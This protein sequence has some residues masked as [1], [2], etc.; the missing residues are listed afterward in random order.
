MAPKA[1]MASEV[2]QCLLALTYAPPN[3]QPDQVGKSDPQ[4]QQQTGLSQDHWHVVTQGGATAV[5]WVLVSDSYKHKVIF[6]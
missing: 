1:F 6:K 2:D 5:S 4:G 3:C